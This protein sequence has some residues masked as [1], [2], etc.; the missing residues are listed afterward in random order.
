MSLGKPEDALLI[1]ESFLLQN[2]P[3]IAL[4]V[5]ETELP[6]YV[7]LGAREDFNFQ[8]RGFRKKFLQFLLRALETGISG[9][10]HSGDSGVESLFSGRIR[11][12]V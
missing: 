3:D 1:G 4:A 7:G 10:L 5:Q 11:S 9:G 8:G 2:P 12:G 6:D